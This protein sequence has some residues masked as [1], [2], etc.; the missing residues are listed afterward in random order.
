VSRGSAKGASKPKAKPRGFVWTATAAEP[1]GAASQASDSGAATKPATAKVLDDKATRAVL[2]RLPRVEAKPEDALDFALRESSKPPPRAGET[3]HGTFPPPPS[4]ANPPKATASDETPLTV[5]RYQPQGDVPVAPRVSV[6]FSH[7]MVPVTSHGELAKDAVPARLT[8][9]IPGDW[10]WIGTQ[11]LLFEPTGRAP[12]ATDFTVTIPGGGAVKDVHGHALAQET[13]WTFSTPAPRLVERY[14]RGSSVDLEPVFFLQF[15]QRV[16][17]D[18]VLPTVTAK[19]G[20]RKLALRLLDPAEIRAIV[21]A[22]P[23][24]DFGGGARALAA[25]FAVS[26]GGRKEPRGAADNRDLTGRWVAFKA[27]TPLPTDARVQVRVGPGTPSAEGPKKT[28]EAQTYDFQTYGPLKVTDH[29]C[30]WR[31]CRP[32]MSWRVSLSNPLD[33]ERFDEG[34]VTVSPEVP[35]LR[36][37]LGGRTIHLRGLTRGRTTYTV[38]LAPSLTDRFGQRLGDSE[39]IT[40]KVGPARAVLTAPDNAFVVLDPTAKRPTFSVFSINYDELEVELYAVQPADWDAYQT[41]R[42]KVMHRDHPGSPPGKRVWVKAVKTGAR[43]DEPTVTELDLSPGLPQGHGQ[44][45]VVVKAPPRGLVSKLLGS[46][47]PPDPIIAW[48]QATP[49]A[50]D[51]F[52]D[53]HELVAWATSLKDGKP[54]AGAKVTLVSGAGQRRE[55]TTDAGGLARLAL[56][57]SKELA[58]GDEARQYLTAR[59]GDETAFLPARIP[60]WGT[61]APWQAEEDRD[62]LRWLVFDDRGLY[63]PGETV[64]VKGFIRQVTHGVRGDVGLPPAGE[65]TQIHWELRGPRGNTLGKGDV[66]VDRFGGFHLTQTLPKTPN[67]GMARLRLSAGLEGSRGGLTGKRYTHEFQIQEFRRPTFQV[68]AR[69]S[70]GPHLVGGDATVTVNAS[71]YAGGPLRAAKVQWYL[72]TSPGSFTPPHHPGWTFGEWSPWWR[73]DWRSPGGDREGTLRTSREVEGETD[74]AG[75]HAVA[76]RFEAIEPPRPVTVRAEATVQD[77]DRQAMSAETTLLVHPAALYVGLRTAKGFYDKGEPVSVEAV[78]ADL[79]GEDVT[80]TEIALELVRLDWRRSPKGTW[81]REEVPA[82]RCELTSTA[83][84]VRCTFTPEEGGTYRAKATI[85]DAEGRP[86]QT[87]F[88]LWVAGGEGPRSARLER[89]KLE[90]IPAQREVAPGQAAAVLVQAPFAPADGVARVVRGDHVSVQHF[91]MDGPSYTLKIPVEDW[92]TP[93]VN[94]HVTVNGAAPREAPSGKGASAGKAAAALPPRP[95]FATGSLSLRVPPTLR[96]LKV[97]AKPTRAQMEP[98]GKT[99]VTVTVTDARGEPAADAS[100]TVVV[101]DESVLALSGYTVPSPVDVFYQRRG[102]HTRQ[103]LLRDD[104][105]LASLDALL[106]QASRASRERMAKGARGVRRRMKSKAIEYEFDAAMAG[107]A[108]PPAPMAMPAPT[109]AAAK[110]GAADGEVASGPI[111]VRKDFN[112]LALFAPQ[113]VTDAQGRAVVSVKLPDNLTRYR[114]F[115]VVAQG[116]DAFGAGEDTITA[117]LPLMVRLSA[118]RFLNFGDRFEL[119]VVLQN[120]TGAPLNVKLAVRATNLRVGGAEP[121]KSYAGRMVR[122]PANDRVEVRVPAAT[123]RAGTARIQAAAVAGRWADAAE[124]SLPVWTPATTEAFATYGVVDDPEGGAKKGTVSAVAQTVR[125]PGEVWPQFGGLDVTTSSTQLQALTDAVLYLQSYPFECS[126]QISSRVLSVVALKDVLAA[127]EAPGLPSPKEMLAAVTR[128][129]EKLKRMQGDDGGWDFWR[130]DRPS[131]PYL[132]VHV[133]HA[134]ARARAKGFLVPEEVLAP[135][136][137]YLKWIDRHFPNDYGPEIRRVIRAYALYVL[138]LLGQGDPA[139]ARALAKEGGGYAKLPLES[140]GWL[141]PVLTG[142]KGYEEDI[143]AIRRRVNNAARE[144]SGMAHFTTSYDDGAYL[145]LAS[146]RRVDALLLDALIG[147]QPKSDLIVKLVRGLLAHRTKGRWANTQESA[148]VLLALDRYF[149]TYEGVTPDFVARVWLGDAL[150]G[151]HAFRGRTTERHAVH[152]PMRWLV[153][154]EAQGGGGGPAAGRD[155]R[156]TVSKEGPGRL[157]YRLGMRYAPRDLR[158]A[159]SNH[160]FTV[161]RSYEAIEDP[162]DVRRND[163]GSWTIR[164]GAVVKVKLTMVS[165]DRRYHVALVDPLPAGLEALNPALRGTASVAQRE[166]GGEGSSRRHWWWWGPWYDHQ[167]LRDERAEA[168]TSLLHAGLYSYSYVARATTPGRFVVPPPKAEEMYA[169]ETFGRGATDIVV[170]R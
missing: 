90:L 64:S 62:R 109:T 85:T 65:I 43:P 2:K 70:E 153:D 57:T 163:D 128:D 108:P 61:R 48:V 89:E 164:A 156:L 28:T 12:M 77:V 69:P 50:V 76:L 24:H 170:V 19:A 42:R 87:T 4:D 123:A 93:G 75:E 160:G 92:M 8:P 6:T 53:H 33:P 27:T 151:E 136:I 36:V 99:E 133:T 107:G 35:G 102:D 73:D 96:T 1:E 16:D 60:Y 122:V 10:Q 100:V 144:T 32:G 23:E 159:P 139:A 88:Q 5:L 40:F 131:W 157:Y 81:K 119:P 11:T 167:N 117:R 143:R 114:V 63:R 137:E 86:N 118:P 49:I 22:P 47:R 158:L 98:G 14:P 105:V 17:P 26:D 125:T 82:H 34:Q 138:H 45:V 127:F 83:A 154:H 111:A 129:I 112:P 130:R 79:D 145:I 101:V 37:E 140:V 162:E 72:N 141:Y 106:A 55:A 52:V 149:H 38:R 59:V 78:V 21:D 18:A 46:S 94:L 166:G 68:S 51:A 148:W 116:D 161:R 9:E 150:A 31:E 97:L 155:K 41:F 56:P 152:V 124:V 126:E 147:D 168:F 29:E 115:A 91:H 39:P 169:P 80:G 44:V 95:A 71:Y 74:S 146:D 104:V 113:A 15:D 121:T 66:P 20:G 134:L 54:I 30:G 67:L 132:T 84:P 13:S 142:A 25:A 165:Q 58:G 3:V 135:A 110:P 103:R 120:Q 7:P